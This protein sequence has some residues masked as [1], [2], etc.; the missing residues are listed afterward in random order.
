MSPA[1]RRAGAPDTRSQILEA[2]R[3]LFGS[4]G[5]D[6]TTIRSIAAEASVDPALVHHYFGTKEELFAASIDLP[7]VPVQLIDHV[8]NGERS[9]IG[10]RL[11]ETFFT[12]WEQEGPRASLL[13]IVRSAAAGEDQAVA[14]FR[15]FMTDALVGRLA[16]VMDG[17]EGLLRAELMAAQLVG[18]AMIRY[19]VRLEPMASRPV[20]QIIEQVAPRIQ[21]FLD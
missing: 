1:G 9:G 6:R 11:A 5:Y 12:I 14:A 10:R 21:S 17:P 19:V 8:L 15:Q 4:N 2:A 18:V 7:V 13:G 16:A 20:E 3:S